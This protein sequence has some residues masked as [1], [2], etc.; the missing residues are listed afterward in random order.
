MISLFSNDFHVYFWYWD[1]CLAFA[2]TGLSVFTHKTNLLNHC[3]YRCSAAFYY[4]CVTIKCS[5]SGN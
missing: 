5:D 3:V 1:Y 2:S 4:F